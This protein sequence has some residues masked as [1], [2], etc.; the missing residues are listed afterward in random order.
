MKRPILFVLSFVLSGFAQEPEY[1]F[2]GDPGKPYTFGAFQPSEEFDWELYFHT[3]SKFR[4]DV[5]GGIGWEEASSAFLGKSEI[6]VSD[7]VDSVTEGSMK[8]FTDDSKIGKIVRGDSVL[9]LLADCSERKLYVMD[10]ETPVKEY[11]ASFGG[12]GTGTG[13]GKTPL[14]EFKIH[15]M[16]GD[17]CSKYQN[18]SSRKPVS[19]KTG[20]TTRILWLDWESGGYL[21]HYFYIQGSDKAPGKLVTNGSIHMSPTDIIDL[22]EMVKPGMRVI[23]RY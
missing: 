5:A 10:G 7:I 22:Y 11:K 17:G 19:R 2:V 12:A 14:G 18:F 9:N 16:F 4:T 6:P 21:D 3:Y 8:L 15:G 1:Q 23:V 13:S 20:V